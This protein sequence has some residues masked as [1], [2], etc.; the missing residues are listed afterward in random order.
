M[1][2]E[3]RETNIVNYAKTQNNFSLAYT[4]IYFERQPT[5]A[6]ENGDSEFNKIAPSMLRNLNV[7]SMTYGLK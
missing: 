1:H 7:K 5:V 6:K 4:V 3:L 2:R